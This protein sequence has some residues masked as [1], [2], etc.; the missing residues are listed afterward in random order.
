[1]THDTRP[2]CPGWVHDQYARPTQKL[3]G[4]PRSSTLGGPAMR[5]VVRHLV[6]II[7]VALA[8]MAAATIAT[9]A[10]NSAECADGE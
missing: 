7:K 3:D 10:V 4:W 5:G 9:P 2:L 1:M 6:P 8:S